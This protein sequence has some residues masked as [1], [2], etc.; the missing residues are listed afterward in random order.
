[1]RD[2]RK[3][4][5]RQAD[6]PGRSNCMERFMADNILSMIAAYAGERVELAKKKV[7][8]TQMK[9]R[10]LE[11]ADG[12]EKTFPFEQALRAPGVSF[13][14]ECKKASP[15]KGLIAEEFPYVQIARE[16]EA[17]GASCISI[18][19]EPKW[20]LGRNEYLREITQS[21]SWGIC[22]PAD[23]F[24]AGYRDAEGIYPYCGQPWPVC[25]CGSP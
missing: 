12:E 11:I 4:F 2:R 25:S 1:M 23:L 10:A 21:V 24:F 16:Y 13:I 15:S 6:I 18:L 20:F 8:L 14:C 22:G 17:A 7:S 19:T 9:R 3:H 5:D